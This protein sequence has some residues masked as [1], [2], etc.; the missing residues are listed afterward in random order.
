MFEHQCGTGHNLRIG[1]LFYTVN[2]KG[3]LQGHSG[4]CQHDSTGCATIHLRKAT[5]WRLVLLVSALWL[6]Q[7]AVLG[8]RG[9]ENL[10]PNPGF[11]QVVG[12]PEGRWFYKG[13]DFERTVRYWFSATTASPDAYGPGLIPPAFWA[14]KG[15]G[16]HKPRSGQYMAGI[17]VYGCTDG[18]PHCRE[19]IQ[20]Q[21]REPLMVGQAYLFECWVSPMDGALQVNSLGLYGSVAPIRRVTDDILVRKVLAGASGML[22]PTKP[23]GWI[24]ISKVFQ[25]TYPAEHILIGNFRDDAGTSVYAPV[26]GG[27]PFG[28]Y[29]IDDIMLKKVPPFLAVPV[30]PDDLT[31]ATMEVGKTF[32]L[33]DIYFEF[34]RDALMP[35]SYVELRKLLAVLRKYP[36]MEIELVG[37]TDSIGSDAYNQTLSEQ[38]AQAVYRYLVGEQIAPARLKVR[39]EGARVPVAPNSTEAG[40]GLNRRV[41]FTVLRL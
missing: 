10:V 7:T 41:A 35:R 13:S 17:T 30:L 38:R 39:G 1:C 2:L 6:S 15:F 36:R 14:E 24:K 29:Y 31:L 11:E 25:A 18:K 16:R 5:G 27:H 3:L 23:G 8:Q 28:Y 37:H 9:G 40:R 33:K 21:L 20:I 26:E 4:C 22:T 19:Y 34:D 32:Q 12:A